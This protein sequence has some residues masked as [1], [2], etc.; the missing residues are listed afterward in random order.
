M[1]PTL[2]VLQPTRTTIDPTPTDSVTI[3]RSNGGQDRTRR[4]IP[5]HNI[6]KSNELLAG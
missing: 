6:R 2:E 5:Y 3:M 1:T 4:H